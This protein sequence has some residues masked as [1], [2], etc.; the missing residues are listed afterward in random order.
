MAEIKRTQ[1]KKIVK[2]KVCDTM[3]SIYNGKYCK[4]KL[5]TFSIKRYTANGM[6]LTIDHFSITVKINIYVN[7]EVTYTLRNFIDTEK[8]TIIEPA[9]TYD[10][11]EIHN[12][13]QEMIKAIKNFVKNPEGY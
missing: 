13:I 2:E 6:C 9:E 12:K 1:M 7:G 11:I 8:I 5:M 10:D 3:L 4:D